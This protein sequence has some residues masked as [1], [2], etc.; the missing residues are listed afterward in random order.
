MLKCCNNCH[1]ASTVR[2]FTNEPENVSNSA[3]AFDLDFVVKI[4]TRNKEDDH[5]KILVIVTDIMV[6]SHCPTLKLVQRAM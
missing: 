6:C 4:R 1:V 5:L 2:T 3:I